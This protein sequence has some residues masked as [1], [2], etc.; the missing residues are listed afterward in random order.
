[1]KRF[2]LLSILTLCALRGTL[3][4]G[5]T[6]VSVR[7]CEGGPNGVFVNTGS[8]ATERRVHTATLLPNGKVLVAAGQSTSGDVASAELY[9]PA[10]GTW[11]ATG[12]LND[13]RHRHAA[14]L[15]NNGKVLVVGGNGDSGP[16]ASAELYDPSTG[17]WT[18][19]GSLATARNEIRGTLL[20][21]G[22]VLVSGGETF[23][24]SDTYFANA[25]LYDP[26]SGTW[27][28]TASLATARSLHSATLLPNGKVLVAGGSGAGNLPLA[29]VE[30]YDPASGTWTPAS[31]LPAPR[32][33]HSAT[34][35]PNG[36]V[37]VA[38]GTTDN[39]I[40]IA[41]AE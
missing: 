13:A 24:G 8:L 27:T 39:I 33:A 14:A 26:V 1:M 29:S 7:P 40:A 41:S 16:L 20:P 17:I 28:A 15:L 25:D 37:L 2:P 11:G 9:D 6:L 12:S 35:L 4:L 18:A 38:G 21:N 3:F 36:K 10:T 32:T 5:A 19:T 22:K 31:S 34:L 23:D 30:L